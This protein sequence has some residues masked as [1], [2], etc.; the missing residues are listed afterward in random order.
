MAAFLASLEPIDVV[1]LATGAMSALDFLT[2]AVWQ[3]L[4]TNKRGARAP[5]AFTGQP[6]D[7]VS[8]VLQ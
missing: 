5:L 3:S 7:R 4:N 1:F 6:T 2:W 8:R